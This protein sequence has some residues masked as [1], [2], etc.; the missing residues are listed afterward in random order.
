MVIF[1]RYLLK[2]R[3]KSEFCTLWFWNFYFP[4]QHSITIV[5]NTAIL[6]LNSVWLKQVHKHVQG[7]KIKSLSS[8][9][10]HDNTCDVMSFIWSYK[11][12]VSEKIQLDIPF[13]ALVS[14]KRTRWRIL[15]IIRV[16][17]IENI[18]IW[19]GL[20]ENREKDKIWLR[21]KSKK[22]YIVVR[23]Q[24]DM[25]KIPIHTWHTSMRTIHSSSSSS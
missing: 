3:K 1:T 2:R 5:E 25:T 19:I 17:V 22:E 7:L 24:K 23:L 12:I 13:Y 10:S 15:E 6:N 14:F 9:L 4:L 21:K 16:I 20:N 18:F 11:T 8:N